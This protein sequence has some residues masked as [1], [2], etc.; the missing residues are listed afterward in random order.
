MEWVERSDTHQ[1][2]ATWARYFEGG[3]VGWAE[4]SD[5]HHWVMKKTG[6]RFNVGDGGGYHVVQ[7][8]LRTESCDVM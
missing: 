8:T 1:C 3:L 4:R 5:T 2:S 7:P 6:W